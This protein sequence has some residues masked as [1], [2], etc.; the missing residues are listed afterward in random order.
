MLSK[1]L[2]KQCFQRVLPSSFESFGAKPV[3][4]EAEISAWGLKLVSIWSGSCKLYPES[5]ECP[6][7]TAQYT[8][9]FP[10]QS[11]I[12]VQPCQGVLYSTFSFINS[13]DKNGWL[14]RNRHKDFHPIKEFQRDSLRATNSQL[15]ELK[16]FA[17]NDKKLSA[18]CRG[19]C[20]KNIRD[21]LV[22]LTPSGIEHSSNGFHSLINWS[23]IS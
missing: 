18:K 11:D 7:G 17:I 20:P 16:A 8:R 23:W 5:R 12:S 15:N 10:T 9:F 6:F 13:L 4:P 22:F 2:T 19:C 1:R 14:K 3:R 21:E